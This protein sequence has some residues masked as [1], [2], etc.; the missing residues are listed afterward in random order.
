M[1]AVD[2]CVD[3]VQA[4]EY[5]LD[6]LLEVCREGDARL[7]WEEVWVGNEVRGPGQEVRD[8]FWCGETCRF[9]IVWWVVP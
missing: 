1:V 6:V 3:A 8:V 9:R 7:G 5:L 2:V 4:L